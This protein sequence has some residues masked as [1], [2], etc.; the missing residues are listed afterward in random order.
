MYDY[1]PQ[2]SAKSAYRHV[3]ELTAYG[4]RHAAT[5]NERKAISYI[6]GVFRQYKNLKFSLEQTNPIV[7]WKERKASIRIVSPIDR[8]ITAN[9]ILGTGSTPP[10]GITAELEYGGRGFRSDYEGREM[11]GKI[12]MHDPPRARTMDNSCA[13]GMPQRDIAY[14]KS[15]GIQALIE[16]CRIPG[17]WLSAP[18]L[19]G[20]DGLDLPCL[21]IAYDDARYLKE[22]LF[23]WYAMPD[24]ILAQDKIPVILQIESLTDQENGFSYNAV[25]TAVGTEKPEEKVILLAHH[26]NAYGPGAVDNAASVAVVLEV[27][28]AL[29]EM[30]G[31]NQRS[32][33][34][35][36]VSGE[37]YG[38]AG[39][40]DY[41]QKRLSE[42]KNVKGCIVMD[43]I[44]GG[45][46]YYYIEKS[47]YNGHVIYNSR[48]INTML[49]EVCDG[50]GLTIQPTQLEFASDDA[51]FIEQGV[52][53]SYLCRCISKSWPWLHTDWDT[54]DVVDPNALK[55]VG[56][57][58]LNTLLR[59]AN[60]D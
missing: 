57:I 41:V 31:S 54:V 5:E 44:G 21:S 59:L 9:A 12:V 13:E 30:P 10:G 27:A 42:M 45:D 14:I 28:K 58:C 56:E 39:S 55:V 29:N 23:E 22:L 11:K 48:K 15:L 50:L 19:A 60:E 36:T 26:D 32:I 37:E 34:L 20:R 18:L 8:V 3:R 52:E 4:P 51:P 24:G 40:L 43:L 35:L 46:Q 25:A 49:E 53:T 16:Y 33:E 2:I 47:L 1:H 17:K 7:K 6:E 38:Q